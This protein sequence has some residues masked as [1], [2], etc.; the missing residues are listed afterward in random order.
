LPEKERKLIEWVKD[1]LN[2]LDNEEVLALIYFSY[3]QMAKYSAKIDKIL[4]NRKDLALKL[5][6]KGKN[7]ITKG[8]SN[9]E[10]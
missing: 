8:Y 1:L 4:K 7:F 2:N 10:R 9:S 6:K 5:Y 3:P